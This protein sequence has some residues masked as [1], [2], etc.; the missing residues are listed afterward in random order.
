PM[1]ASAAGRGD[2]D[3]LKH[4]LNRGVRL[5]LL[6]SLPLVALL[7]CYSEPIVALLFKYKRFDLAATH[8][9]AQVLFW[10]T[11]G[12]ISYAL[13]DLLVRAFYALQ[14]SRTPFMISMVTVAGSAGFGYLFVEVLHWGVGGL[15]AA[16]AL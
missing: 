7:L 12:L 4:K 2:M 8:S 1:L 16:T 15:A 3:D 14:D 11:L 6:A 13:R 10:L 9:T 5:V